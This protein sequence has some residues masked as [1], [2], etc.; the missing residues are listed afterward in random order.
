MTDSTLSAPSTAERGTI[1]LAVIGRH[2][3]YMLAGYLRHVFIVTSILL[4]IALTIDLWPQL[5]MIAESRGPGV[6]IAIWSVMR[7]SALR[8]PGLI[9]PFF[10]FATYIGIVWTEVVHTR[11][12]ERMLIWNSGRSPIQCLAP[13]VVLGIVLGTIEFATDAYL[14]PA[15]MGVQMHEGLGLDGQ[16]LDRTR[17]GDNHW[18][19]SPDGLLSTEIEYGPPSILHNLKYYKRDATGQLIEVDMAA[20]AHQLSGARQWLMRDGRYWTP[21][22]QLQSTDAARS[23]FALNSSSEKMIPFSTRTVSLG[24]DPLWLSVFGM[25]AQYI[26]MPTLKQLARIDTGPMS[27]GLYRTRL[28]VLYAETL[29]PGAM[30]LLAASLSLLL[31]AYGTSWRAVFGIVFAGYLAH[32]GSKACLLLGQN[33]YMPPV[34]AGWSVPLILFTATFVVLLVIERQRSGANREGKPLRILNAE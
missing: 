21:E 25:E 27:R 30:A 34:A 12:G 19:V 1:H 9:A 7:Y 5:S 22:V 20:L 28:Q 26:P 16:R 33:G 17:R 18:I 14:G 29:L 6:L 23:T 3:R 13:V 2:T 15:A 8:T 11:S 10:P 32:F 31:L 4:A 24:L